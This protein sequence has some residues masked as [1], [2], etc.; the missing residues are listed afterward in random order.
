MSS[1][2]N[3]TIKDKMISKVLC[4]GLLAAVVQCRQ[5]SSL[6]DKVL[7]VLRC[8]RS[9]GLDLVRLS[10]EE[11]DRPFR[12]KSCDVH[13]P[14]CGQSARLHKK[15]NRKNRFTLLG[16]VT[17]HR[18][19]YRCPACRNC[20]F[21]LDHLLDIN[22][23]EHRGH[24]REFVSELVL[25][26]TIVPYQKGCDLFHRLCGFT[27]SHPLAWKLTMAVGTALYDNEMDEAAKLWSERRDKPE[28]FEPTP[29]QLR[30]KKRAR[31]VYVM[32]D[33][34][35]LG[36]QEGKRGRHAPRKCRRKRGQLKSTRKSTRDTESWR[37]ARALI[38]FDEQ[39]L[40]THHS[41]K[42]RTIL[43]RRVVAHI[44]SNEEWYQVV[45]KAFYDEGVY[46]AHEVVVIADG[47]HGI[48]ELIDELLPTTDRRKVVQILDW[49][50][51]ASHIW[52]VGKL[53]KG[54]DKKGRPTRKCIAWVDG[55]LE[56]LNKGDVSNVLQRLRKI[57]KGSHEARKELKNLIKYFTK[58]R[59]RMRYA[60]CRKKQMLIGSGAIESVHKWVIQ[61]RCKLPGMRWSSSGANAM[62]RLRCAWASERWDDI[63]KS[64]RQAPPQILREEPLA[65]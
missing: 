47:G 20:F 17:Y 15:R 50:H 64:E 33:N 14:K 39:D 54:I 42:R 58:H 48:W 28:L 62:L 25:L 18:C 27:V 23:K 40:A 65:A 55:L 21:P 59:D 37:D 34:S 41:G 16:K 44:G 13:C 57:K 61:V 24:S 10:L 12:E 30:S 8:M 19:S 51:A 31:R 43:H 1:L 7:V 2:H 29:H 3:P 49:F 56:Y 63:F 46:W 11:Q 26:C 5:Q 38:I 6:A 52:T 32:L 45:H 22:L 60:W 9:I 53:L 4:A 35:K 36:M